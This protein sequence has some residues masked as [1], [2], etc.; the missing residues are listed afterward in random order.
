MRPGACQ[1]CGRPIA[2]APTGRPRL[3]CRQTCRQ[4]AYERRRI[5]QAA[6]GAEQER[7]RARERY[8]ALLAD[9]WDLADVCAPVAARVPEAGPVD[10]A[11]LARAVLSLAYGMSRR[12]RGAR[13]IARHA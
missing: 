11:A 9:V 2:Q 7:E 5:S 1:R 10:P 8:H 6:A 13:S 12:R 3:Y 4:R